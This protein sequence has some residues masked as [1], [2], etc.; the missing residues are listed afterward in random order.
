MS[1]LAIV[2]SIALVGC[3]SSMSDT[4]KP[5]SSTSES[6]LSAE[7][8]SALE[9]TATARS[10]ATDNASQNL[11][12]GRWEVLTFVTPE[13]EQVD[14]T[15]LPARQRA[16]LAWELTED[17]RIRIGDLE[18]TFQVEGNTIYATNPESGNIT[19]FEFTVSET[20]LSIVR[21]DEGGGMLTLVRSDS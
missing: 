1:A 9:D 7:K 15:E 13:G 18:G 17:G 3:R 6:S 21:I 5:S 11:L 8:T 16:D 19:A 14:L 2:G 10:Q 4:Q 12:Y 20:E